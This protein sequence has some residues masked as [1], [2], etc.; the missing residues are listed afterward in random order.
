MAILHVHVHSMYIVHIQYMSVYQHVKCTY[1][2][3][4][5]LI[6]EILHTITFQ[7]G[8]NVFPLMWI[9]LTKDT[10]SST[11]TCTRFNNNYCIVFDHC[12]ISMLFHVYV[13]Y[14]DLSLFVWKEGGASPMDAVF[15]V[16]CSTVPRSIM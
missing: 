10:V 15:S 9:G 16:C 8:E 2:C 7:F 13:G 14:T 12:F 3:M 11:C 4:Y 1:I 5:K 6:Q